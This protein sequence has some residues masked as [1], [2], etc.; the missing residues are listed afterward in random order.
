M[1]LVLLASWPSWEAF[2]RFKRDSR[3][4]FSQHLAQG[5]QFSS[6]RQV[7][8]PQI[9]GMQSLKRALASAAPHDLS[10][11]ADFSSKLF[12][13]E[14]RVSQGYDEHDDSRI[15]AQR[16]CRGASQRD[17][18]PDDMHKPA[19][20]FEFATMLKESAKSYTT[21]MFQVWGQT[22]T[23][24]MYA[25]QTMHH[26]ELF[27]GEFSGGCIWHYKSPAMWAQT[28]ESKF[29]VGLRPPQPVEDAQVVITIPL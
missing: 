15:V 6:F 19:V 26:P 25:A 20:V 9:L 10:T 23:G 3:M 22:G 4:C 12:N 24:P 1:D 28:V 11:K 2:A 5:F 29:Y 27:D 13:T 18:S 8:L 21:G 17:V 7:L 16:I 14:A